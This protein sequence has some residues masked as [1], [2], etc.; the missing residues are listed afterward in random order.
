MEFR[1]EIQEKCLF[2][3]KIVCRFTG[4]RMQNMKKKGDFVLILQNDKKF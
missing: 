2:L 1:H 4:K 3:S